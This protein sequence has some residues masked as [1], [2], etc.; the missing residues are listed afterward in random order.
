MF[1]CPK[2]RVMI[3]KDE[4]DIVTEGDLMMSPCHHSRMRVMLN[5]GLME[6]FLA[7]RR[8]L[9]VQIQEDENV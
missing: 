3:L 9:I 6:G 4:G 7:G 8:A 5:I 1:E 2:N